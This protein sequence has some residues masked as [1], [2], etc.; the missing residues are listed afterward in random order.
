MAFAWSVIASSDC[1]CGPS[2]YGAKASAPFSSS[3]ANMACNHDAAHG[4]AFAG[5][6]AAFFLQG[7]WQHT[8][9]DVKYSATHDKATKATVEIP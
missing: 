3:R 7:R 5:A 6:V 2:T 1:S 8:V 4:G 9:D